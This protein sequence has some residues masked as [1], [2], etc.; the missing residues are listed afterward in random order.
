MQ[1]LIFRVEIV[2]F[3]KA[4]VKFFKAF[5]KVFKDCGTIQCFSYISLGLFIILIK[6][7]LM[8]I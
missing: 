6:G 2:K 4:F 7:K 5:V 8:G 3:F 1:K